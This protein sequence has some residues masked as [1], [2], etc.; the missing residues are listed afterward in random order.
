MSHQYSYTNREDRANQAAM[1]DCVVD[2]GSNSPRGI[3][4]DSRA[5]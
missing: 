1:L 2:S 5:N 3:F 4:S